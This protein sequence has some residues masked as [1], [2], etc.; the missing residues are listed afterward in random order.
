MSESNVSQG[1]KIGV[2]IALALVVLFVGLPVAG[3]LA[4]SVGVRTFLCISNVQMPRVRS[5]AC[6]DNT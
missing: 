1:F 6:W 2:G 3:C 5:T 4:F